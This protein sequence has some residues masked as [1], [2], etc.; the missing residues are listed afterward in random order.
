MHI[1]QNPIMRVALRPIIWATKCL[2]KH[3][4][5]LLMRIRYYQRFH[6]RL[7]LKEPCTLNEKIL[8]L[9]L[10]T[11]TSQWTKLADKYAVRSY[12]KDCGLECILTKLYKHWTNEHEVQFDDLPNSFVLKSVQGCGDVIIVNNKANMDRS[13]ISKSIHQMFHERYGALEGGK[14]YMRITPSVIVEELLPMGEEGSLIDYKIWCFNGKPYCILTCSER[15]KT[16]VKLGS[17]D[18]SW[19]YHPEHLVSS[20]EHPLRPMPL[21]KP[22]NLSKMLEVAEKLSAPFP[23][24]RVDLYD[25]NGV[26]YFGEMTFTAY[27]GMMNYY[28]EEFQNAAGKEIDL[29]YNKS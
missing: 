22:K 9:S 25:I 2:G 4:P 24:V 27:G 7:N 21:P 1:T 11:D 29:N 15:T 16:G 8:Y 5:E 14:H 19:N 18:T 20:N 13:T 28:S 6:K 3:N 17:Y 26:V 23:Q 10:K 12:V